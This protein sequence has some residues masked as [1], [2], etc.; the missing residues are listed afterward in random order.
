MVVDWTNKNEEIGKFLDALGSR[1][2]PV[3][4]FFNASKPNQPIVLATGTYSINDVLTRLEKIG[5]SSSVGGDS[6][7]SG[8]SLVANQSSSENE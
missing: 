2:L 6:G 7:D 3:V 4:A 8:S 5:P 1:Q